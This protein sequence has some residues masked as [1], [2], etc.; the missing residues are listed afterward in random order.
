MRNI[1]FV[2]ILKKFKI[3]KEENAYNL[4]EKNFGR[5]FR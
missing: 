1:I 3:V 2:N 5:K 4:E